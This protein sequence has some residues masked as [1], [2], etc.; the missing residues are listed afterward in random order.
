M[1][2]AGHAFVDWDDTIAENIRYFNMAEEANAT[3]IARL[4][5]FDTQVVRQRGQENDVA[6]ARK[7]GLVRES[8]SIA[9]VETYREFCLKAGRSVDPAAEEAL[10]LACQ[11]P[12][13]VRQELLA[14]A[15]ETL[16]WLHASGFE[17]TVWTAGDQ[18]VQSRKIAESGLAHLVHR[19]EI[20]VDKTPERLQVALGA[21]NPDLCFVVGN[22]IHSDIRPA[23]ALGVLALHVP[24]ETWA[25]DHAHL[26]LS[27][28]NYRMIERVTDLPQALGDRFRQVG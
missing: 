2:F 22:S 10:W 6:V 3:L 27:D 18:A 4:T 12:Y 14:G 25:Y 26:D 11:Q 7:M 16:H 17:V 8:F 24:A 20:V 28:P 1:R 9:W 21:R 5:G 19:Q 23:L 15:A 13:E